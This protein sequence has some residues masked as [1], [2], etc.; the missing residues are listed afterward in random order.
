[1][2]AVCATA[3]GP[4]LAV[5]AGMALAT[6]D[7]RPAAITLEVGAMQRG[8]AFACRLPVTIRH[9]APVEL[10]KFTAIAKAYDGRIELASTGLATGRRPVVR[11][12][13]RNGVAYEDLP[14]QFELTDD[15]CDDVTTLA[16]TYARCTFAD[17]KTVDC[18]DRIRFRPSSVGSIDLRVGERHG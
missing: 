7:E 1:M 5:L 17:G 16:V 14:L 2:R 4:I 15:A 9:D 18:L 6:A 12:R 3:G 10:A 13:E 8:E 11:D